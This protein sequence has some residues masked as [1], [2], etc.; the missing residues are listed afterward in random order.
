MKRILFAVAVALGVSPALAAD[1]PP[2]GPPPVAPAYYKTPEPA[3]YNWSGFYLGIN[4]GYGFGTGDFSVG[5]SVSSV[6]GFLGGGTL[7]GNYQMGN[8]V[9][10]VEGDFDWANFDGTNN[11]SC[12][13]CEVK[14]NWLGTVRGRAG[15]AWDRI[16]TYGTAGAAF[17]NVQ[18]GPIG[19]PFDS[20]NQIGW[21]AGVGIEG[22]FA[23]NWTAKVEYLYVDLG[24]FACTLNCA[25]GGNLNV[26]EN[27]VRA[28]LNYKFGW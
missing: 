18:G 4:G 2:P 28:G 20:G 9:I 10:G 5:T 13:S 24:N 12:F 23:P 14:S 15:W 27:I 19:G 8:F 17:A 7:G 26:T 6:D 1:L 21:T 11:T 16:L 3:Y 22:A 25:A